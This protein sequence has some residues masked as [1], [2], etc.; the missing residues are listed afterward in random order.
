MKRVNLRDL[1]GATSE[2]K[3]QLEQE[4]ALLV[5]SDGKPIAILNATDEDSFEAHMKAW[6]QVRAQ[7]ALAKLQREAAE[8]GLDRLTLDDINAEIA[9]Y[10]KEKRGSG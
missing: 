2:I 5:L 4:R 9:K 1:G 10:R 7:H 3:K 6:R 8:R